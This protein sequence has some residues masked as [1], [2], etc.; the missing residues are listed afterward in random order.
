M[1]TLLF[2]CSVITSY[3]VQGAGR[4]YTTEEMNPVTT[5]P[6][7]VPV[8]PVPGASCGGYLHSS[9]GTFYSPRYPNNYPPNADCYWYIR[10]GSRIVQLDFSFVDIE[11]SHSCVYDAIYIYD[12]SST[13]SRLLGKICGN[14]NATFYST[15]SYLTVR[16]RSD[17]SSSFSGFRAD[18]Q[19][20]GSC[21]Y[22][23]G[24]QVGSCSC[25]SSCQYRGNCCPDY[26]DECLNPTMTPGPT[27][28]SA[29]PSCRYN[30]GSYMG[31]CSCTSSCQYYGNCCYDYSSY[32]QSTTVEPITARPSCRYNCGSYMGSCSCSSS[33]QYYGSCCYDY[34]S[35]CQ[36]STAAPMIPTSAQPSCRY[37][38]GG[39]LGSC[40]CTSSCRYY[41]NCCYDYYSYCQSTTVRPATARPSCRYNCG[42]YLGSCSCT[43]S[44]RYYGNCCYDYSSYCQ[45]STAEPMTPTSAQPSCRYNCGSYLGSCSC[46]SSCQSYGNCCNDYYS[47]CRVTPTA[48]P[49]G[50][51]LFGSGTFSSPNYPNYY[52]DSAYC[53]WQLRAAYDQRI[54]LAF[55]YMQL[56]NCCNCD[57]IAVYDGPSVSSRYLGKV[58]NSSLSTFY[59][60]SNYMTVL[61]RTDGS[62]VGRGFNAEFISSLP[63][64][65]GRVDCSSDNMNIVVERTYLNSLGYDGHSLYLNDPHCRPQ[66]SRYQVV[67]SFP[68]NT[69]GNIRKFE[70]GRVVYT[71]TLRAY[72]SSYGEITRQSHF[73]LNVGCRMEQDSVAQI[74]YLVHHRGNSSITGTGRFNT[75]M[76]FYTSSSFYYK[77]TQVPYEVALNQNLYVQVELRRGD[78]TLV[79]FLDTC[80]A[81]PSPHDFQSRSYYLV[82]NGCPVDNTY[83][84]YVTGTRA[85]ARF[86]FKGFQF[87]R[88]TESVYIQCKV[89]ICPA[90][91]NNSRC[92][93]GCSKRAA[94]DVGSEHDSQTLVLGPIQLKE[95][96]KKEEETHEQDKA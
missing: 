37:N 24:L 92:R 88:A 87:L 58:C 18:Y 91:D 51:S 30:C 62:V 74:M 20:V 4:F 79:L 36:S 94:R 73:K 61:F 70:N 35:Y 69:C 10:P 83:Q 31:S 12:G 86:T 48:I 40:S 89:Q 67:F 85:Y 59:S 17:G 82:R 46:S 71:N 78:S 81:S 21:R 1:W 96:E 50:G 52:H 42:S 19:V 93:R 68:I 25:S 56:E 13:G 6:T 27:V 49:C 60:S 3:G 55:T 95:P 43:S 65:S 34:S 90:S 9:Y 84:A 57:Y 39:H 63:P 53:T 22:N 5:G 66:V 15:G 23:C 64:S 28:T 47:Y 14:N 72:A 77:V 16:F 41:G 11:N 54:F 26:R 76:D 45:S 75:S 7:E 29:Q 80:V 2:L 44:C 38:C 33:C 32:C 8:S